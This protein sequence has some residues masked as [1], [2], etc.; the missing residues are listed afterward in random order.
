MNFQPEHSWK[1]LTI[2]SDNNDTLWLTMAGRGISRLW[3][4][5]C[6]KVNVSTVTRWLQPDDGPSY[7]EMSDSYVKLLEYAIN[8][9]R[10]GQLYRNPPDPEGE[11]RPRKK[12]R[13]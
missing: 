11:I 13:N 12:Y 9:G 2:G 3:V 1:E 4:A 7:R 8:D 5:N 10:N 6:L